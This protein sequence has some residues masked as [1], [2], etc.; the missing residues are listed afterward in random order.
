[1]TSTTSWK[2]HRNETETEHDIEK[3][4]ISNTKRNQ[5]GI[6]IEH[7]FDIDTTETEI[8]PETEHEPKHDT[9][10]TTFQTRIE[11]GPSIWTTF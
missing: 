11:S 2:Q 6:N 10:T 3:N 5:N 9:N 1:M 7:E 8:E 4:I